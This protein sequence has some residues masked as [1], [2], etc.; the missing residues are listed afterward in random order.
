MVLNSSRSII[1]LEFISN[2]YGAGIRWRPDWAVLQ[3]KVF[4]RRA[5]SHV[6]GRGECERLLGNLVEVKERLK[7]MK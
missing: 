7:K 3:G 6:A 4:I 1:L 2:E 5:S